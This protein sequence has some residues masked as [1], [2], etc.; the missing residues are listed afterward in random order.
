MTNTQ[1]T[2]LAWFALLAHIV[3][4]IVAWR[5][6]SEVPLVPA[7]NLVVALC[8][9]GYAVTQWYGNAFRGVQWNWE[10]QAVPVYGV[11]M[12]CVAGLA[13][14]G[15]LTASWPNV[16]VFVVDAFVSVGAVVFVSTFRVN[17]LF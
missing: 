3:V 17:R 6:L 14:A 7:L 12:L 8:V 11:V 1:F 2:L 15:R 9:I 16:F 10:D 4:G 5:R 13:L